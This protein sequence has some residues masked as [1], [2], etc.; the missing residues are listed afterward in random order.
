MIEELMPFSIPFVA[1][2]EMLYIEDVFKRRR[3][4]GD[5]Y[6]T[7]ASESYLETYLQSK[8]VLLTSSCTHA[9]EMCAILLDIQQGDEVIMPSFNF[10]SAAN[11]FVLRGAKV[12][13]VDVDPKT[14][15]IS[16]A[17]LKAAISTKTKAI[18]VV[19]YGG[20]A[21]DMDAIMYIAKQENIAVVEDAAHAVGAYYK[22]KHLGTI[23]DLGTLSFHDTKNIHC[24]EGGALVV[25]N[26]KYIERALV[27]RE[28][29]T[30][31]QAFLQGQVDKYTWVD[32]GSSYLMS[33][34]SAAVLY[35]QL[36]KVESVAYKRREIWQYYQRELA[37]LVDKSL[38]AVPEIPAYAKF[39]AHVF[40]L[41]CK[42]Q[43]E[44]IDLIAHLNEYQIKA[45]FHYIPLH[46]SQAGQIYGQFKGEDIYT[47]MLSERLLRLPLYYDMNE[48]EVEK[49]VSV[50]K[51]FYNELT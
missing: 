48:M 4:C 49:I 50:I 22:N 12:V 25:N 26:E 6:Y 31:R 28:K 40:F 46:T 29:G 16:A 35:A 30:N 21:C 34:I 37:D 47:T 32:V 9:L 36:E 41:L 3:F 1:D 24:G 27:L 14:M 17:C 44:R 11:A 42:S 5:A 13:F 20:V 43:K 8:K 2:K 33:E 51:K 39:N 15:N 23:G 10:V 18:V 38:I 7:K 45:Y 19:H